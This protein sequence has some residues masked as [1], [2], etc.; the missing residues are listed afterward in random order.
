MPDNCIQKCAYWQDA[1]VAQVHC[2]LRSSALRESQESLRPILHSGSPVLGSRSSVCQSLALQQHVLLH[3]RLAWWA[4]SAELYG[5]FNAVNRC[6]DVST[7]MRIAN[8]SFPSS[9]SLHLMSE[10]QR[11]PL[12]TNRTHATS[13]S[14]LSRWTWMAHLRYHWKYLQ[15]GTVSF[16]SVALWSE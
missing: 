13:F 15:H 16:Q 11:P 7:S 6:E 12:N 10:N 2:S 1:Q 3:G 4:S 9:T 8:K 14:W 5:H